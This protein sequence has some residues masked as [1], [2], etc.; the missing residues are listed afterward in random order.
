MRLCAN[1]TCMR[2][3]IPSR[4]NQKY[5]GK[6]CC[7]I[8][9]NAK[10]MEQY[11]EE[12]DRKAGKPRTCAICQTA[13]LSRYN[14]GNTCSACVAKKEAAKRRGLLEALGAA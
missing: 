6:E 12:K 10:I 3:F 8:V 4:H 13:R 14:S 11:Y 5:C 7:K 1:P 9:T 2:S